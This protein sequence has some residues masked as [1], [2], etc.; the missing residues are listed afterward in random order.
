MNPILVPL[1]LIIANFLKICLISMTH[2]RRILVTH[3]YMPRFFKDNEMKL[4]K[5]K[6]VLN[7]TKFPRDFRDF[8]VM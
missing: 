5:V 2:S 6:V 8:V 3:M 7:E 4:T 1:V